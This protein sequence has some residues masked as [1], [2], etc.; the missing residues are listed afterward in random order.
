MALK[1]DLRNQKRAATIPSYGMSFIVRIALY[2]IY[3]LD[4]K[5]P[6]INTL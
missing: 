6:R 1:P 2:N 4:F 3:Y 5:P